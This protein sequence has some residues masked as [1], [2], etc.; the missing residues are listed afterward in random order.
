MTGRRIAD[1]IADTLLQ[2]M[3]NI[4]NVNTWELADRIKAFLNENNFRNC[5][6]SEIQD[7]EIFNKIKIY[8]G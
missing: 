4:L 5:S 1:D 3:V 2:R 6:V 7:V 8:T